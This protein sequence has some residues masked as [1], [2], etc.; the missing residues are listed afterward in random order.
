[1]TK[2]DNFD[3]RAK[4]DN[5]FDEANIKILHCSWLKIENCQ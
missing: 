2:N 3:F 4:N 5:F 1:M